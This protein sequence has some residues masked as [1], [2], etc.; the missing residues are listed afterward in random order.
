MAPMHR[1]R[2]PRQQR[3]FVARMRRKMGEAKGNVTSLIL[4]RPGAS[5]SA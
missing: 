3:G 2:E 5:P 1:L 4:G